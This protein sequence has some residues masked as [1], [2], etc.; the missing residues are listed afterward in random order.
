MGGRKTSGMKRLGGRTSRGRS[1]LVGETT[2]NLRSACA[3]AQSNQS[4]LSCM[5]SEGPKHFSSGQ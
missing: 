4:S 2:Q 5:D 1:G 3:S